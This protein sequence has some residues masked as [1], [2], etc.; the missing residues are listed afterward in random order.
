M[1]VGVAAGGGYD[2]Y[3]RMVARHL[4]RHIPG[5]PN[6]V[7][8]NLEGA[9]GVK[10]AAYLYQ[11][12]PNDGTVIGAVQP[13]RIFDPIIAEPGS[14]PYD[15]TKFVYIG[16]AD[17]GTRVCITNKASPTK[18]FADALERET[19][20][21]ATQRGAATF[22]YPMLFKNVAKARFKI[23]SGYTTTATIGLAMD[24]GE[25][26]GQCG[27]D[28]SSLHAQQPD[29]AEKYNILVQSA[30][31][32][33]AE[34]V[35]MKIPDI[36]QF[37]KEG[38]NREILDLVLSQQIFGRPFLLPPGADSKTVDL[39]RKA[40][41]ETMRD[42]A[43]LNDAARLRLQVLAETG[44]LVQDVVNKLYAS[45]KALIQHAAEAMKQ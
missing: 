11:Q 39:M 25:V 44:A 32:P 7:V 24:G 1:I 45:P 13:G 21:G 28:W 35:D 19:L 43:F 5:N 26:D 18:T 10:A 17:S 23:I 34:L 8:Q 29:A 41:D 20:M 2:I 14:L 6:I 36:H 15:V 22:D 42:P 40:F 27:F 9:G 3:G 33:N 37:V 4:G 16:T 12:A 38:L 31:K 30:L